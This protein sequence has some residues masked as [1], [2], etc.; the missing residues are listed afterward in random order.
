M[1]FEGSREEKTK[2]YIFQMD[3]RNCPT[4]VRQKRYKRRRGESGKNGGAIVN[5]T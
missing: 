5:G 1:I 4:L 3:I 2:Y